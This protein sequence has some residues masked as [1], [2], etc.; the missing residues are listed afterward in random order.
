MTDGPSYPPPPP[1][2]PPPPF[3]GSPTLPPSFSG[4]TG[5]AWEQ[6]GPFLQR[7][8][9]T[10]K[11]V[12]TD[13]KTFFATM[14]TSGGMAPPIV[15][16]LVG[17]VI[18]SVFSAIWSSFGSFGSFGGYGQFGGGGFISVLLMTLCLGVISLFIGSAIFHVML[19]L[20]GA[21]RLPFEA[22]LRVVA[23]AYGGT[24]LIG[25]IPICGSFIGAIYGLVLYIIGLSAVHECDTAK[26]AIAVLTPAVVCCVLMMLFWG[27]VAALI[28]G[29]AAA[30]A[31]MQ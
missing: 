18:M 6:D 26:S 5:P 23:Y 7:Y 16:A 2:P 9:D 31:A 27:A 1:P 29:A 12:L 14:R 11:L 8:L 15:F 24:S 21:A 19:S 20:L 28:F 3:P 4:R 13:P 30:G 22:T 10:V 25:L 17:T